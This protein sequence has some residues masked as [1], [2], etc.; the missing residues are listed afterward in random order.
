MQQAAILG[1]EE[2]DQPV[3][4]AQELAKEDRATRSSPL[5]RRSRE[6]GVVRVREEAVAERQQRR[7]DAVAQAVACDERPPWLPASRQRSSA[8]SVGGAPARAEAAGMEQQP[9]R[10]EVGEALAFEDLAQD[11]PRYRPVG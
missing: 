5:R 7:L 8:Q 11:R 3:D 4:E 10:G 2:E 6:A 9:E 1:G